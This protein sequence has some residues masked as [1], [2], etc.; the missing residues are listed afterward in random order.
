MK[1]V[2]I[3]VGL[4][5][6]V[7]YGVVCEVAYGGCVWG[8]VLDIN[9]LTFEGSI[10]ELSIVKN[11]IGLKPIESHHLERLQL[12]PGVAKLIKSHRGL[13]ELQ[14]GEPFYVYTGRGPFYA[15]LHIGREALDQRVSFHKHSEGMTRDF[16]KLCLRIASALTP[17]QMNGCFGTK[18]NGPM[19]CRVWS[20]F[21]RHTMYHR[22]RQ[23]PGPLFSECRATLLAR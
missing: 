11:M 12:S 3:S 6:G 20:R 10:T 17:A 4:R 23:R 16:Y 14:A 1:S 5:M 18:G 15:S 9:F 21:A 7:A 13:E 2:V 22:R 19:L 8:C